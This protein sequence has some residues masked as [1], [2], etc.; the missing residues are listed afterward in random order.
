MKQWFCYLISIV[1]LYSCNLNSQTSNNLSPVEFK[2]AFENDNAILLDVRTDEE[3][4]KGYIENASTIDFYDSKFQDKLSK[5]QKDKTVYV[6][7]KSGGRSSKAAKILTS[8]GQSKVVNLSG[9]FMAWKNADLP[10]FN[11]NLTK[12]KN[13]Q[14]LSVVGFNSILSQYELVLIDFH[15]KWC[16]PCRKMAPMIDELEKEYT[17]K[18]HIL[19]VDMDKSEDVANIN[20]IKAVPTLVLYEMGNEAW[21]NTGLILKEEIIKNLE[22]AIK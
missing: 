9:G 3:I 12:D 5:I 16:A 22:N 20:N 18:V 1:S 11:Q 19:R 21:R 15:T 2:K 10:I 17:G 7:C 13:I 4:K 14:E 6:Y 8:L